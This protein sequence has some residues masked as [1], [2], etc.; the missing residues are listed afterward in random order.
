MSQNMTLNREFASVGPTLTFRVP[1][2]SNPVASTP[3][4]LERYTTGPIRGLEFGGSCRQFRHRRSENS[5]TGFG[6]RI[7]DEQMDK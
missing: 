2:E 3:K 4:T 6:R 1:L 7:D 5:S